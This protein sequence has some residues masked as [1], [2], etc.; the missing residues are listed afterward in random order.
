M[1]F[2]LFPITLLLLSACSK[3]KSPLVI[4]DEYDGGTFTENTA[5]QEVLRLQYSTLLAE[6]RKGRISGQV[7]QY[8]QLSTLLNAGAPS[9]KACMTPYF[10]QQMDTTTVGW[11]A[12]LAE[13]S[14]NAYIP[15]L[16]STEGGVYYGYLF[17][18]KGLELEQLIEKGLLN[19][20]FYYQVTQLLQDGVTLEEVDQMVALFG[21]DPTFPNTS[22]AAKT[23][24]PDV[25]MA[26]YAAQRDKDDAAG[27]YTAIKEAFIRLQAAIKAGDKYQPEQD[28]AVADILR[29]WEKIS[30]ASTI[31]F[32]ERFRAIMSK[33]NIEE[34]ER[35][36]ALHHY[37]EAV[38][39]IYGWRT[40]A[41]E[42]KMM[43]DPELD[44]LLSRLR[45]APG[46]SAQSYLFII[47]PYN[48]FPNIF[49]VEQTI[50][51]KYQFTQAEMEDFRKD[52]VLEQGR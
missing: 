41:K 1:R 51:V 37:A 18:E 19:A 28:K 35:A 3:A 21:A 24:T 42:Y 50:Q 10:A 38:G 22:N 5:N 12:D 23:S 43:S 16:S 6:A 48:A 20:A 34:A 47:D 17:N 15:G 30:F 9:L 29:L 39:M 4:P 31:Y 46:M 36:Q 8:N 44:V 27:L 45:V 26:R 14:G 52:W 11:L 49:Q 7:V 25:L 2:F 13:S 32:C 40:I 33:S